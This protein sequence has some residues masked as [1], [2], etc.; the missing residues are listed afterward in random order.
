MWMYLFFFVVNAFLL[1]FSSSLCRGGHCSFFSL[2][3]LCSFLLSFLACLFCFCRCF[4][5]LLVSGFIALSSKMSN[6]TYLLL[7][8]LIL[9]KL[10]LVVVVF[11][12]DDD[13]SYILHIRRNDRSCLATTKVPYIRPS[14]CHFSFLRRR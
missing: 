6:I 10:F 13:V 11:N 3:F 8:H 2:Y 4:L 14:I 5:F 1:L 12:E 9:S 7:Y